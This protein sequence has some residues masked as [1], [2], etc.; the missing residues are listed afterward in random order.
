[1][2]AKSATRPTPILTGH[3]EDGRIISTAVARAAEALGLNR[4]ETAAILGLSPS[5]ATRLYAGGYI[6]EPGGKP[7]QF[8]LLLVRL[9]RS[10]AG[11]FGPE[12]G[13]IQGWMRTHNLALRGV[14]A[15]LSRT[16]QGLVECVAY[17][18]AAR[19]PI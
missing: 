13:V 11:V 6:L 15:E 4:V 2:H 8:A 17:A 3:H 12:A 5:T 19:A 10:L 1:M 7:Y 16:P 14:P 9:Y 18:D